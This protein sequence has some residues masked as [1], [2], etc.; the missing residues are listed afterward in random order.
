M[1]NIFRYVGIGKETTFGSEATASIYVDPQSCTLDSPGAP[2]IMISGGMGRM[3]RTKKPGFYSCGGGVT[4]AVDIKS[5]GYI[6][7]GALDQY[8]FTSG[9]DYGNT[10]EFY[11]GD[12]NDLESFTYRIGKD[13]HE[14]VFMGCTVNS[15]DITVDQGLATASVDLFAAQDNTTTLKTYSAISSSI[16][17]EYP[18]AF[19][20]TTATIN[21]VD[22]SAS[23]KS[24]KLS[25][26]NNLD[27]ESG[28]TIG[29]RY[30]RLFRANAR[31]V[32][33]E[34]VLQ[35]DD[36]THQTLFWGDAGGPS[37][38][39]ST[40]FPVV[41]E[42][43]AGDSGE[44]IWNM[45]NCMMTGITTQPSGRDTLYQTVTCRALLDTSVALASASTVSTDVLVTVV[46]DA[47]T[48]A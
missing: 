8:V 16:P 22:T 42:F 18:L 6:L 12:S 37:C 34:M 20:E 43:D 15:V 25:I 28:R 14:Q 23:C 39:G 5:I 10:H 24:V 30:P 7:R 38:S 41:I 17:S 35:F 9:G 19:Y 36:L 1:V 3:T 21:D 33:V 26:N 2:E 32:N 11:G 48:L 13:V 44:M 27:R 46:S 45:E 4:Y 40:L 29:S 47:T 31:E